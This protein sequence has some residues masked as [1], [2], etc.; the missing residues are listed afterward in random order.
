MMMICHAEQSTPHSPTTHR[1]RDA[2]SCKRHDLSEFPDTNSC[3]IAWWSVPSMSVIEISCFGPGAR[4]PIDFATPFLRRHPLNED[5]LSHLVV[6]LCC[7]VNVLTLG[8]QLSCNDYPSIEP[9]AAVHLRSAEPGIIDACNPTGSY[10]E[11]RR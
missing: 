2:I 1:K 8:P 10:N 11:R 4:A 7:K 6:V 5:T 3:H 9:N